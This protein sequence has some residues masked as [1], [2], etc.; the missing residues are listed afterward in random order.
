M[1][2]RSRQVDVINCVQ[3]QITSCGDG[4]CCCCLLDIALIIV[5]IRDNAFLV[6]FFAVA[7]CINTGGFKFE[8]QRLVIL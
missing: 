5:A 6:T 2:N 1:Q 4:T 7:N 3:V 8:A